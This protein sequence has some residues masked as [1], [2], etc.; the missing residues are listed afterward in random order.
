MLNK[1]FYFREHQIKKDGSWLN[2]R[3]CIGDIGEEECPL[4]EAGFRP[5]YVC[6][7]T[8]IDLSKYTDKR[9]NKVTARKKLI[10]FKTTAWN[11]IMKRRE[12]LEDDLTGV[13]FETTRYNDKESSTGEFKLAA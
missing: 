2:W 9:G 12:K 10:L 7:F 6:A 3:T 13:V 1:M 11:K 5:S 8:I 4:C